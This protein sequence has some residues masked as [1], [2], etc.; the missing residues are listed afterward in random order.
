MVIE[1]TGI[2]VSDYKKAKRFYA[3]A[4]KPLG[5][6]LSM[7]YGEAGG[8][9][10]GGHT[11]FWI[12]KKGRPQKMHVAF[13]ANNKKAVRDFHA[14]ALKAGGKDNGAPGPRKDYSPTYY[15]AF[16]LDK[17]GNNIEAVCFN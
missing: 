12:M 8:F 17:D 14:A 16:V 15:A 3:A 11:D 1:H 5:Y 9:K 4:L 2:Y 7:E 6:K 10:Q 13:R